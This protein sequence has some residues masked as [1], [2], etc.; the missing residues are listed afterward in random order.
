MDKASNTSDEARLDI[1]AR[2]FW[3]SGQKA[4]FDIRVFNPIARRYRNSKISKAYETNK[5]EKKRHYSQILE[6]EHGSF[7]FFSAMGGMG[8]EA[9]SSYRRLSEVLS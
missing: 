7:L 3:I 2:E 8:R 1:A 4:F 9:R 6:V 5:K